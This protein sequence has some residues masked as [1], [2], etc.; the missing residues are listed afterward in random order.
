MP[1]YR[2]GE[3]HPLNGV[4]DDRMDHRRSLLGRLEQRLEILQKS[5]SV[6]AMNQHYARAFDLLA[7]AAGRAAFDLNQEPNAVRDRY[8]RNPHGQSV[9]QARRLIERGV[10]LTGMPAW[11]TGTADG[12]RSSWELVAFIRHLP[13]LTRK[14]ASL[15]RVITLRTF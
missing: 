12:A 8:G 3:M 7:S 15:R 11:S 5:D 1:D 9:L 2:V 10:P 6:S 14:L 4:S 13:K